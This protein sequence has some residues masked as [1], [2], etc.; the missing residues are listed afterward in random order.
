[1]SS[2]WL[3]WAEVSSF[4]S[5]YG[6]VT[7]PRYELDWYRT[8]WDAMCASD[9]LRDLLTESEIEDET[10]VKLHA[11]SLVTMYLGIYQA[12]HDSELNACFDEHPP[13][14]DYIDSIGIDFDVLAKLAG[15]A[16]YLP[17]WEDGETYEDD[18]YYAG[19]E[20]A[21]D[22]IVDGCPAVFPVIES[23]FG[24]DAG[25]FAAIWNSRLDPK[26]QEPLDIA[27]NSTY[28]GDG[29]V[30]V[31]DYVSRGMVGWSW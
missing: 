25:L 6:C 23:H 11:I 7:T 15:S 16:G 22:L 19:I 12:A 26:E 4:F 30:E 27:V 20:F 17:E 8:A 29:K 3:P 5:E 28:P 13:V 31:S 14:S 1:M 2:A 24:G 18:E 21:K 9:H 10:F